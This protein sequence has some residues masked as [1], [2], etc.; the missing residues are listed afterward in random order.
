M[1]KRG[2]TL[3][4]KIGLS[5]TIAD[6]GDPI[7][8]ILATW[9]P[10]Y[11]DDQGRLEAS[12]R[13]LKAEVCP[14]LDFITPADIAAALQRMEEEHYIV[15]YQHNGAP[16]LQLVSWWRWNDAMP[17]TAASE[18]PAPAGWSDC[19]PGKETA[20]R[21]GYGFRENLRIS[22]TFSEVLAVATEVVEH[23]LLN[24]TTTV[25]ALDSSLEGGSG[26]EPNAPVVEV[27]VCLAALVPV[28]EAAGLVFNDL[29][30]A[31]LISTIQEHPQADEQAAARVLQALVPN[32]PKGDRITPAFVGQVLGLVEDFPEAE[33]H[34]AIASAPSDRCRP[35]YVRGTI[36]GREGD[37]RGGNGKGGALVAPDES[38]TFWRKLGLSR[39]EYA[40]KYP[41]TVD[42]INEWETERGLA[43]TV[44]GGV[45]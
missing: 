4:N 21:G 16:L 31:E 2:R 13:R 14:R 5:G 17:Y 25:T 28:L 30:A 33:I 37:R 7:A 42:K 12:P 9:F 23:S 3:S 27:N 22:E 35:S 45:S 8:V 18:Y 6:L 24:L 20:K 41:T 19:P 10:L 11:A 32:L 15:R 40:D 39:Q 26:G 43:L 36:V 38:K 29:A 1:S 34:A 44:P